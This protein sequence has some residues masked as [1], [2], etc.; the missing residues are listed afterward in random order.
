ME[1]PAKASKNTRAGGKVATRQGVVY[2]SEPWSVWG[3][4]RLD[5]PGRYLT[6]AEH[7]IYEGRMPRGVPTSPEKEARIV[8]RLLVER[9]ASR[10]ARAE[11]VSFAKV[12]R[13]AD[14]EC[15]ELTAG[16]EA[17]GYRRLSTER[18]A[19]VIEARCDNPKEA[20]EVQ[21]ALAIAI[22]LAAPL[23]INT[24]VKL[25]LDQHIVRTRRACH[26]GAGRHVCGIIARFVQNRTLSLKLREIR[27]F[28]KRG[29]A[30]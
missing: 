12:W 25:K 30:D 24:L 14:R 8:A 13:L 10:V 21:S 26:P 28:Q 15:I 18:R 29:A 1:S 17:K 6:D 2:S 27:G 20:I 11:G 23:R 19:A 4:D 9:H 22:E 3:D 5:R 7:N 16:Q